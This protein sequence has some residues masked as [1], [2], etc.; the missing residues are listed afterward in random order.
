MSNLNVVT[1]VGN[2]GNEPEQREF[3]SGSKVTKFCIGVG[4]WNK[5]TEQEVTDWVDIE[6]FNKMGDYVKKGM[7]VCVNGSLVTSVYEK[8]DGTKVKRVYVLAKTIELMQ[9][10]KDGET[11]PTST[12]TPEATV[13]ATEDLGGNA[14]Y[15]E[16]ENT[17]LDAEYSS[18]PDEISE[19][20]IPF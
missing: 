14:D 12:P 8:E 7:K 10:K 3:E 6:T 4:R 18:I 1:L 17:V 9:Q 20:E 2:V 19:D 13:T 15:P 11:A 5:K 16:D